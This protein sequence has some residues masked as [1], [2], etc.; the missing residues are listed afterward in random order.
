M[1]HIFTLLLS[2]SLSFASFDN[3]NSFEADFTQSVTDDKNKSL[4][5]KGHIIASKPQNAVWNYIQPIK[6]D[7]Y[8]NRF[9][10]TVIE[11]EI[12]QVIIRKIDAS[13]DFFNMIQNAKEIEKDK[14]EANYK[15]SK[16]TITTNNK[17]I[18]SISYI[19]EFENKVKIVFNNQK[20]N[21]EINKEIFVPK[22]PLEFDIIRD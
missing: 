22:Y 1:K 15:E 21:E 6:K 17:I 10:V 7:V 12:E 8:I 14:Y 11:P 16:F 20:Q 3:L 13:L 19:D 18:K 2:F 9:N 4:V 5:Y